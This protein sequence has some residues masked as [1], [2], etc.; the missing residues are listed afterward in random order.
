MTL[1]LIFTPLEEANPTIVAPVVSLPG[2]TLGETLFRWVTHHQVDLDGGWSHEVDG[3]WELRSA[4]G[5]LVYSK[6]S[7]E[8]RLSED[9]GY[10][11]VGTH[12]VLRYDRVEGQRLYR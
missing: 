5:E 6:P 11:W 3:T 9:A 8:Y 10:E 2:E 12:W 4:E 7:S 1:T